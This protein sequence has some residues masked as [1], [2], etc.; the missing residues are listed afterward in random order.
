M[1]AVGGSGLLLLGLLLLGLIDRPTGDLDVI[2]LLQS[3][4][5]HKLEALPERL[6]SA[7]DEV[8]R[9]LGLGEKWINIGPADLMDFGL[10]EGWEE[11]LATQQY[12]AL[13][14]HLPSREDQICFKLY[15]AADRGP[16]DKH[17]LDLKTLEPT[18]DEL[19]FAARRTATHD[20]S[21]S[22]RQLQKECLA[23]LGVE[24]TDDELG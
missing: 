11:R 15:A 8:G 17:Y 22:F 12:G 20:I 21:A 2:A 23:S 10:P 19:V 14:L 1:L 3:G 6:Q 5:F 7:A 24:V 18:R 9:A 16:D 4:N 13:C